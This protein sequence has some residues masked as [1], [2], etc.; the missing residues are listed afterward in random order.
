M[1]MASAFYVTGREGAWA[2]LDLL[3][4]PYTILHLS[5]CALGVVLAPE[6]HIMRSV[7]VLIAFFCAMGISAHA[8]DILKGAKIARIPPG[9]L[10]VAATISLILAVVI[11]LYWVIAIPLWYFL[12]F[13]VAGVIMCIG[14][15]LEWQLW[16]TSLHTDN[17]FALFW[18]AFPFLTGY[19]INNPYPSPSQ[20]PV[21]VLG[22]GLCYLVSR[23]QR[24]LSWR[25][26]HIRRRMIEVSGSWREVNSEYPITKEW[27]L[28][29]IEASLM[30]LCALIPLLVMII[31]VA[32]YA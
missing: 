14:Y 22:A 17:T 5:F 29:P 6:I 26:R 28:K 27:M 32:R 20:V 4:W 10:R 21:I 1:S 16:K 30:L 2:W 25:A 13:I 24:I 3:H 23:M 11:G 31:L 7:S 8:W 15:N 18:G 9:Q 12:A 19:I